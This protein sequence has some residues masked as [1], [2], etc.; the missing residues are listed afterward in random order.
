MK[1]LLRL[2]ICFLL[3]L[4]ATGCFAQ[5]SNSTFMGNSGAM[6]FFELY[7]NAGHPIKT[8][9]EM[10]A[11]G[12]PMLFPGW[13]KGWVHY[14]NEA[15]FQDTALKFSLADK[16]LYYQREGKYYTLVLPVDSFSLSFPVEGGNILVYQFKSG[17][18]AIDD[19][20]EN[21]FY[22]VLFEGS[23][24]QLLE[25]EQKRVRESF[26]YGSTHEKQYV[27]VKTLYVYQPVENRLTALRM[28][29]NGLKKSF[30][31]WA[32]DIQAYAAVNKLDAKNN[33]QVISLMQ[34]IDKKD[35]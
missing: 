3:V 12:T 29:L 32:G 11:V 8:A 16:K 21:T 14:R 35:R 15:I 9:N 27:L 17:Y 5:M 33:A 25:L 7:D 34:Y 6:K 31:N 10:P 18:P 23:N 4:P 26:D 1:Q 28:S 19:Q 2:L 22:R 24:L 30:P 13:T 20:D